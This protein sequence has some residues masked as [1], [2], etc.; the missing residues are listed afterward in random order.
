MLAY[1]VLHHISYLPITIISPNLVSLHTGYLMTPP[2]KRRSRIFPYLVFTR[3]R[4]AIKYKHITPN[5]VSPYISYLIISHNTYLY[6]PTSNIFP[7]HV[8]PQI[9]YLSIPCITPNLVSNDNLISTNIL[10]DTTY[11]IFPYLVSPKISYLVIPRIS[12]HFVS[13]YN[14]LSKHISYDITSRIFP[15]LV[16]TR[17]RI[18]IQCHI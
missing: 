17:Y 9:S 2:I 18:A 12:A 6:I 16:I 8:S 7:H 4:I 13:H 15:F 3:Y 1:H 14:P 5:L 10:Y 11:R